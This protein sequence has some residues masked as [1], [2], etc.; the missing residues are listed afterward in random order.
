M[1]KVS[2]LCLMIFGFHPLSYSLSPT[3]KASNKKASI[4]TKIKKNP[5]S[6]KAITKQEFNRFTESLKILN[7]E[8]L[9]SEKYRKTILFLENHIYNDAHFDTLELLSNIYKKNK[10]QVNQLKILE[11]LTMIYPDNPK[12]HYKIGLAYKEWSSLPKSKKNYRNKAISYLTQA[13]K[14]DVSFEPAYKALLPL[15]KKQERHTRDS[16]SLT[17]EMVLYFKK[18]EYYAEL[19]EAYF[20]NRFFTHSLKACKISMKKNKIHPKSHILHILSQDN[21]VTKNKDIQK[22]A[23]TYTDSFD[24][25][26]KIS[27][28]FQKTNPSLAMS[29]MKKAY[30]INPDSVQLLQMMAKTFFKNGKYKESYEYF[31]KSCILTRGAFMLEFEKAKSKVVH[32]NESL[33]PLFKEG[34]NQCF[35]SV[36]NKKT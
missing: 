20:D 7:Q 31:L 30:Q 8:P 9:S 13:T 22:V 1:I 4:K 11:L 23:K 36:T 24:V 27:L 29:Y 26:Y 15:L 33:V 2:C 14:T 35:E 28:F 12:S 3:A 32:K 17:K 10:D 16:L 34:L 18:P 5:S 21:S 25:Q 6:Q 19:C